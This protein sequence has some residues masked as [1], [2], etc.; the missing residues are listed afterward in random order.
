M[1]R[2]SQSFL[3][4]FYANECG[5]VLKA[6][7][8]T[9]TYPEESSEAMNQGKYFEYIATGYIRKGDEVPQ[10]QLYVKS[11]AWGTA[12]DMKPE[13]VNAHSHAV[14]FQSVLERFNNPAYGVELSFDGFGGIDDVVVD[15]AIID[16]KYSGMLYDKWSEYGWAIERFRR[17]SEMATSYELLEVLKAYPMLWQPLLYCWIWEKRTGLYPDWYYYICDSKSD[18]V[19]FRKVVISETIRASFNALLPVLKAEI[20]LIE[21]TGGFTVRPSYNKC[22]SC[23]IAEGCKHRIELPEIEVVTI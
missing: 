4:D 12:G 10:P 23:A 6:K 20:E 7:Y 19:V 22:H 15:G 17:A 5:E 1:K 18:D 3:K 14:R 13:Y 2:I 9:F 21:N 16:L 8:L 11:G